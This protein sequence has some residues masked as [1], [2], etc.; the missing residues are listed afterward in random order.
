MNNSYM[1]F[2]KNEID[3]ICTYYKNGTDIDTIIALYNC[4][5]MDI[6]NVLK[7]H[8]LDRTYNQ[9]SEELYSRI[10]ELYKRGNTMTRIA[11]LLIVTVR[12]VSKTLNNNG[13]QT[14]TC[15]ERNQRYRRNSH[16]FD[17]IDDQYKAYYLGLLFA[18][19]CN[20]T[21]HNAITLSLQSEDAY[22]VESFA[23][24]IE[25]E[26]PVRFN[27]LHE[28]NASLKNQAILT[29]N[30]PYMSRKL[31]ELGMVNAKSLNLLFP[32]YITPSLIRHFIRGYFDGD[33]CISYNLNHRKPRV[34]ICGTREFCNSIMDILHAMNCPC[35]LN[36]PKQSGE[37]NTY[38][39]VINGYNGVTRFMD[40]IYDGA[41]IK[42][43]RKYIKYLDILKEFEAA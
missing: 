43:N 7:M 39:L 29:V 13:I 18:D 33:G 3:S 34:M 28:K 21:D 40:W 41:K 11:E 30:D 9:F 32:K 16:Y 15:S 36:H 2:N 10:I 35:H 24:A 26:G 27:K 31:L 20:Y 1:I 22:I 14:R 8:E 38:V 5:E 12:T 37:S 42:M 19:G 25:Y 23:N 4:E 6:R 17:T